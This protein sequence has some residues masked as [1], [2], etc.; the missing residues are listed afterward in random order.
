MSLNC[1]GIT[2]WDSDPWALEQPPQGL[3]KRV[4]AYSK[5]TP[6]CTSIRAFPWGLT[7]FHFCENLQLYLSFLTFLLFCLQ[8]DSD[9]VFVRV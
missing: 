5:L 3:C 7:C 6:L 9:K 4:T 2:F 8:L 1:S